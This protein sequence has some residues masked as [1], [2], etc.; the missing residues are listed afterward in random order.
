MFSFEGRR[1][2]LWLGRPFWRPRDKLQFLMKTFSAVKFLQFLVI[3]TLDPDPHLET[4]LDPDLH[5][6]SADPKAWYRILYC[7]ASRI[8]IQFWTFVNFSILTS[9]TLTRMPLLRISCSPCVSSQT[10]F[11]PQR[12]V[13]AALILF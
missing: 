11:P 8:R 9:G 3:Q 2:L 1:L 10:C 12:S 4:M 7:F 13:I 6:I 5:Q